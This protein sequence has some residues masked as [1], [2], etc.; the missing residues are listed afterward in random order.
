MYVRGLL[1]TVPGTRSV[2]DGMWL[3]QSAVTLAA[4]GEPHE[5]TGLP[6]CE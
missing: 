5:K 4:A 3:L 2:P 1:S 6:A